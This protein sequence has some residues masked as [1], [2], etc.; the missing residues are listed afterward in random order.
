MKK[1]LIIYALFL[2]MG[3][4]LFLIMG[5]NL[6]QQENV[7]QSEEQTEEVPV[8]SEDTLVKPKATRIAIIETEG[9]HYFIEKYV[10]EGHE[11]LLFS[12]RIASSPS[13]VH[14]A[15]CPCHSMN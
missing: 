3:C 8:K 12:D 9:Y 1:N 13:V 2:I 10:I 5:C 6:Q 4:T 11:Y 7:P 14:S 15:S